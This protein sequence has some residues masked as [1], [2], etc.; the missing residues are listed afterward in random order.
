MATDAFSDAYVIPILNTFENIRDCLGASSVQLSKEE[1]PVPMDDIP[2]L[3]TRQPKRDKT[4]AKQWNPVFSG[5]RILHDRDCY[6]SFVK[7]LTKDRATLDIFL[8]MDKDPALSFR[9]KE[10]KRFCEDVSM[11]EMWI[12]GP[13]DSRRGAR[14]WLNDG[15]HDGNSSSFRRYS[16][17]LTARQLSMSL[18]QPVSDFIQVCVLCRS[19]L[20]LEIWYE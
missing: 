10:V 15:S 16:N 4:F 1:I 8:G 14:A 17:P 20:A 19:N 5:K 7:N 13:S 6:V 12:D 2:T 18:G 11:D 9:A 3:S